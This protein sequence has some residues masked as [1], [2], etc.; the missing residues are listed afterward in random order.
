M[1][2]FIY[3]KICFKFKFSS[4]FLDNHTK[5]RSSLWRHIFNYLNKRYFEIF[6]S[7]INTYSI[8]YWKSI[9]FSANKKYCIIFV[10]QLCLQQKIMLS[11][12]LMLF[13]FHYHPIYVIF[14]Q[15]RVIYVFDIFKGM[16]SSY[17]VFLLMT[18]DLI[19]LN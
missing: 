5:K 9:W 1:H 14:Q 10:L 4:S 12:T 17:F 2:L 3:I 13:W 18:I 16:L 11:I 15:Y 6:F 7:T 19:N 8:L